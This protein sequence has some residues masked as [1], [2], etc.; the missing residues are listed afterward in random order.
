MNIQDN[1]VRVIVNKLTDLLRAEKIDDNCEKL[2][3]GDEII[4]S[5]NNQQNQV[6]YGRRG[7]GKTIL[8]RTFQEKLISSY[9]DKKWIP[10]YLDLRKILPLISSGIEDKSLTS[11]LLFKHLIIELFNSIIENIKFIFFLSDFSNISNVLEKTKSEAFFNV[12]DTLNLHIQGSLISKLGDIEFSEEEIVKIAASLN[13]A[14][15]PSALLQF[16]R[17]TVQK[18]VDKKIKYISFSDINIA[19]SN[20]NNLLNNAK[21]VFLL[22]EWSEIDLEIQPYLAELL[23]RSFIASN[24]IL[25]IAAIPRRTSMSFEQ[26]G[27]RYGLEDGGDIFSVP[28]DDKFVYEINPAQTRL[29]FN[30]M[31]YKHFKFYSESIVEPYF[32]DQKGINQNFINEFLTNHA[33]SDIFVASAGIPR[34]FLN[35]FVRSF[36]NYIASTTKPESRIGI[37]DI[38]EATVIWYETDKKKEIDKNAETKLLL[39]KIVQKIVLEKKRAQ[40]L[41]PN[42]ISNDKNIQRLI[43]LR[44]LHLRKSGYSHQDNVG[45]VYNIYSIDYGCYSSLN[46]QRSMLNTNIIDQINIIQDF[47]ELRR[48]S[49]EEEDLTR[50]YLEIG[51]AI[52]CPHCQAIVY[53]SHPAF[54][55]KGLCSNCYEKINN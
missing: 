13:I 47:R 39:E 15:N 32:D 36:L 5:I 8:L 28:I 37:K 55:K 4:D 46:L 16:A 23:K 45:V 25:K 35:I 1:E 29:F 26:N 48:I 9:D 14:S 38:R 27:K 34:D 17:D 24:L 18:T 31:L 12:L 42:K 2:Y 3:V 11:V 10:I 20:L 49:F 19:F 6:I 22:D 44:V 54:L 33:L 21:I 30:N 51:E 50:F 41:I 53:T 52:K 7:S 43:D 40:F